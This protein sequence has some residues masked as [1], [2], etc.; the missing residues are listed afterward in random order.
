MNQPPK[1]AFNIGSKLT[2]ANLETMWTMAF[3][4]PNHR[5]HLRRVRAASSSWT[6]SQETR[7]ETGANERF[8]CNKRLDLLSQ[9]G[10][11]YDVIEFYAGEAWK[12]WG[13]TGSTKQIEF[14]I[15]LTKNVP[16]RDDPRKILE[17][18][19]LASLG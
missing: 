1:F 13:P 15:K 17:A 4:W 10:I 5:R 16:E 9:L 12:M 3:P 19:L 6:W 14:S 7:K 18:I 11:L 8:F 2:D